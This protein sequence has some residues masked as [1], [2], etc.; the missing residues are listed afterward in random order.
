M[1]QLKWFIRQFYFLLDL[2]NFYYI[3]LYQYLFTNIQQKSHQEFR[4]SCQFHRQK[5]IS[6]CSL[7]L[8]VSITEQEKL[9]PTKLNFMP[10]TISIESCMFFIVS[11]VR[12]ILVW[13]K[14]IDIMFIWLE[15]RRR[16][17][18]FKN[19]KERRSHSNPIRN[20]YLFLFQFS[21]KAVS[22]FQRKF[23]STWYCW[24]FTNF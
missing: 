16:M 15:R 20:K 9:G 5:P 14:L 19:S 2:D 1:Q 11:H 4:M 7:S 21:E 18:R 10:N 17:C 3:F 23:Q 22:I 6:R 8:R 13:K 12:V 24:E